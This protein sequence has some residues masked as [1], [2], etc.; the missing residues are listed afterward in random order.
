MNSVTELPQGYRACARVDLQHNRKEMLLVNGL[1]AAIMLVMLL[2]ALRLTPFLQVFSTAGGAWVP[3]VRC[4]VMLLGLAGYMVLHELVHGIFM[5]RFSGVKP[6][7]GFRGLYAYAGSRAYFNKTHYIIIAL[8]PIVIW[9]IVL[10]VLCA[11]VPASWFGVAYILE[12]CNVSGAAGDL[13]VTARLLRMDST[14]LVQDTGV[15]MTVFAKNQE[16]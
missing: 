12:V 1:A 11:V 9:G 15:A 2:P 14:V 16:A 6:R 3:L 5:R 8:A 10:G 7:Y 13:Y 4:A